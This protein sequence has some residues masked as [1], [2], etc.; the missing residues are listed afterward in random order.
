MAGWDVDCYGMFVLVIHHASFVFIH[1]VI[2]V[3]VLHFHEPSMIKAN[4]F[5]SLIALLS[6]LSYGDLTSLFI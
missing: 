5:H 6:T 3:V 4:L 1:K 2:E